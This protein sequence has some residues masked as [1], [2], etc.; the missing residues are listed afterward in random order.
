[1]VE[2][3]AIEANNVGLAALVI[4][5]A[6]AALGIL[7]GRMLAVESTFGGEIGGNRLVTIE[8]KPVLSGFGEGLV[9]LAAVFLEFR[10]A[11]DDFPRHDEFFEQR[12]SPRRPG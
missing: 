6:M 9:A 1:M 8:T 10:V 7:D 11:F 2:G 12:F 5:M 3:L 4:G